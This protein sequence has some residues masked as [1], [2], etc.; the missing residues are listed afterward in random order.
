MEPLSLTV[1]GLAAHLGVSRKHLSQILH[2]RASVTSG[3]ALRLA[4]AF[5]TTADLWLNLQRKR[6]LWEAERDTP[7]LEN[8]EPLPGLQGMGRDAR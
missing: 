6:D 1:T 8:V 3:L 2:E 5:D 4:R 7:G